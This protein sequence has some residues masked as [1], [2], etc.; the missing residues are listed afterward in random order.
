MRKT[1]VIYFEDDPA[2]NG[3]IA[4]ILGKDERLS[5]VA[6]LQESSPDTYEAL[7]TSA[8]VAIIDLSMGTG[9]VN[10]IQIGLGLRR[11]NSNLG[12]V[13]FSQH[14]ISN[15]FEEIPEAERMGWSVVQ[16]HADISIEDLI[17]STLL[18]GR[19]F[20]VQ[21]IHETSARENSQK[22]IL[23]TPRQITILDLASTGLSNKS[24]SEEIG[25]SEVSV[26]KDL[27]ASYGLLGLNDSDG[28][29]LRTMAILRILELRRA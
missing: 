22:R 11:Y 10:G 1:R 4:K 18:S 12:I 6:S 17:E 24:I 28:V 14:H 16:K 8:D 13:I 23:L 15:I 2:L 27:S 25:I 3:F 19:G 26:R 29:D 9:K 5:L 7:A 21:K 20:S